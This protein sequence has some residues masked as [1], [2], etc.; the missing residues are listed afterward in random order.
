ME[1]VTIKSNLS[2][3]DTNLNSKKIY[4]TVAN[5]MWLRGYEII[6]STNDYTIYNK[7]LMSVG[8]KMDVRHAYVNVSST[9]DAEETK[10][11]EQPHCDQIILFIDQKVNS[12]CTKVYMNICNHFKITHAI[13][14][15]TVS[16]SSQARTTLF[17]LSNTNKPCEFEIFAAENLQ[18]DPTN[19]YLYNPHEMISSSELE[20]IVRVYKDITQFPKIVKEFD[21]V[22][23]FFNFHEGEVIRIRRIVK[24]NRLYE[25]IIYRFVI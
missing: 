21:V 7:I 22:C 6:E 14:I 24:K 9:Q 8:N 4:D 17:G 10:S 23:K 16:I 12:D 19:H 18:V 5:M 20:E 13:V 15:Y 1:C 3:I 2:T 25:S 11:I